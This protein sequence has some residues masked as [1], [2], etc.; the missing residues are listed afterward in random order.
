MRVSVILIIVGA[1]G[2]IPKNPE[3]ELGEFEIS[4]RIETIQTTTLLTSAR[5]LR[6][7]LET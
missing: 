6:R 1:L 7:V 5:I 3:K 4:D 2:T